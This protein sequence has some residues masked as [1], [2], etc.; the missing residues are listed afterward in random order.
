[1]EYDNDNSSSQVS[2]AAGAVLDV[3]PCT[4]LGPEDPDDGEPGRQ[5]RGI[6]IAAL[7][8][9]AKGKLGY[10]VPSQ[11]G[12][13]KYVVSL[14][15]DEAP[16]CTCP[17]F[18]LRQKPCKHI[19][20]VALSTKREDVPTGEPAVVTIPAQ[21]KVQRPTYSQ[22]WPAYT[23]A[24]VT[25]GDH[26]VKL[27]RELCDTVAQ[28]PQ[29]FG[30]PRLLLGDMIFGAGLKVYSTMS[31]R[32]AMSDLRRAYADG[33]IVK[34]PSYAT[35]LR[36]LQESELTP[37]LVKLIEKS[38]LPLASVEQDF[39]ID[40][41]GFATT[42]YHRWFDHKWGKEIR[43]AQWVKCHLTCGVKTN[44]VT[45]VEVTESQSADA[46][47]WERFVK[48]TAKHFTVREVSGDKAYV[49]H[50]NLRAVDD[51]GGKAYI[52]FKVNSVGRNKHHKRDLL[53][54]RMFHYYNFHREEFLEHYHRRSN[55]ETTMHMIKAKF[56]AF[57]RAKTAPAQVNEALVKV[58]C[59][60]IVVLVGSMFELGIEPVFKDVVGGTSATIGSRKSH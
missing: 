35:V 52:P 27:L 16:Y 38:S 6:A 44:I 45:A 31:G 34:L 48:T 1:M 15:D 30:R 60:N 57:V 58:L 14:G 4:A 33:F 59:H 32:R 12:N 43:E 40:S 41:T 42:T 18:E 47:Y 37:V 13:G 3:N 8:K 56:G 11:S 23:A 25:E 55:V 17:D 22:D 29:G 10:L 26:F 54:E 39:A 5:Q 9:I 24:Q 36:Y 28:P 2:Q 7:T 49:S 21:P 53:W 20:A 46:V 50:A 19:F 51:V